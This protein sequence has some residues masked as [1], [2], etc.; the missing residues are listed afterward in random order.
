MFLQNT[1]LP[2]N[3]TVVGKTQKTLSFIDPGVETSYLTTTEG[4]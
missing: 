1:G 3:V 4:L 2:T